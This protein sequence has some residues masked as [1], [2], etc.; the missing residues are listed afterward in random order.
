MP[1]TVSPAAYKGGDYLFQGISNA[2]NSITGAIKDFSDTA[3]RADQS[4]AL[5]NYLSQ[6]TDPTTGKPVIDPKTLQNYQ[7]HNMRQRAYVAGGLQAGNAF[8]QALQ[9]YGVANR[10]ALA[11]TNLYQ[12]QAT[13]ALADA[14]DTAGGGGA[15]SGKI[16]CNELNGY[17]MPTQCNNARLK[18]TTG[19]LQQNYGLTPNDLFNSATHEAGNVAVDPTSG[20]KTFTPD[21]SGSYIRI[22]ARDPQTGVVDPNKGVSM[23][24]GEFNIYKRQLGMTGFQPSGTGAPATGA[25]QPGAQPGGATSGPQQ[26]QAIAILTQAGKPLTPANIA[27]VVAQLSGGQ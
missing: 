8:M 10:E 2:A 16:W 12:G 7:Q 3:D 24:M 20:T 19:Q 21:A 26:Q 15:D 18:S 5:M 14:A 23:P 1:F 27:H 6:Q 9:H 4:D 13:K 25:A 17:A 11:R 22:G